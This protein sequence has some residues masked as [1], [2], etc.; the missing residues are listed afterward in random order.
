MTYG[1]YPWLTREGGE[2]AW[3]WGMD[4]VGATGAEMDRRLVIVQELSCGRLIVNEDAEA[5]NA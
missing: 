1:P 5:D 4:L 3:S 2:G